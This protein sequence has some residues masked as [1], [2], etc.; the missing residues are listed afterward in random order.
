MIEQ[1]GV[2]Y[3]EY[4]A[5]A[6]SS[7]RSLVAWRK[8]SPRLA[9]GLK[10]SL[11]TTLERYTQRY[12]TGRERVLGVSRIIRG[13]KAHRTGLVNEAFAAIDA[14]E[15]GRHQ[16]A[17]LPEPAAIVPPALNRPGSRHPLEVG[18]I[19]RDLSPL[20]RPVRGTRYVP[21]FAWIS[22]LKANLERVNARRATRGQAPL[23]P[24]HWITK[25]VV[26]PILRAYFYLGLEHG[27][28][29][30]LHTQNVLL[31]V[32][33]HG[34]PTGKVMVKD[35]EGF[36]L[37]AT[38]RIR[39]GKDLGPLSTFKDP[40]KI[41][42][43]EGTQGLRSNPARLEAQYYKQIRN[44]N[45]FTVSRDV[46]G[47]KVTNY[48]TPAGQLLQQLAQ[49]FPNELAKLARLACG[50]ESGRTID[51]QRARQKGV[52]LL[53]DYVAQTT[54]RRMT[55]IS[56]SKT[57]WGYGKEK[58]IHL[59]LSRLREELFSGQE[60]ATA[61]AGK[62]AELG[63]VL[64]G[65]WGKLAQRSE[66]RADDRVWSTRR[67]PSSFRLLGNVI[68]AIG[69]RGKPVGFALLTPGQLESLQAELG[70]AGIEVRPAGR[71]ASRLAEYAAKGSRPAGRSPEGRRRPSPRVELGGRGGKPGPLRRAGGGD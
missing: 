48:S 43:H 55:G 11:H 24:I 17:V 14:A 47:E 60:G 8:G 62:E 71:A 67:K 53:F 49:D 63:A 5:T 10:V 3:G 36:R 40:F 35:W 7:P 59:G 27:L 69:H 9:F 18:V 26:E 29:G 56:L 16:L 4:Q 25:S 51:E 46:N 39:N 21:A 30:E 64:A 50:P 54:F 2:R 19:Y 20:V 61:P 32:D 52:E 65:W 12:R 41:I 42:W 33:R 45:G 13:F 68:E 58:G 23:S 1:Y 34:M 37:D 66:R 31:E 22:A 70:R 15:L 44:V 28:Q 6:S 38:L 57:S